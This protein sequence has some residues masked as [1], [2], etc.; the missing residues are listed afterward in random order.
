LAA[1]SASQVSRF[2]CQMTG[3]VLESRCCPDAASDGPRTTTVSASECCDHEV[4]DFARP[5]SE[6]P[7]RA[8]IDLALPVA[9][10][11]PALSSPPLASL[12]RRP[13]AEPPPTGSL[14]LLKRALL[15]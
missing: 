2:R 14:V 11:L 4:L 5:P 9:A 8:S 6:P 15:I 10:A 3:L 1:I 12:A 13:D 7:A